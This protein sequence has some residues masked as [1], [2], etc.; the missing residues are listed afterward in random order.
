MLAERHTHVNIDELLDKGL[1]RLARSHLVFAYPRDGKDKCHDL[2]WSV[3]DDLIN[4]SLH[5]VPYFAPASL[6]RLATTSSVIE[7]ATVR[8]DLISSPMIRPR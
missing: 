5:S 6:T 1:M 8:V 4:R 3:Y 2:Q 7:S